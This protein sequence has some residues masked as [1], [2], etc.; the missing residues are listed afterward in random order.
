MSET[1]GSY[2]LSF[3]LECLTKE[4]RLSENVRRIFGY[5]FVVSVFYLDASSER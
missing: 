5:A 2:D 4:T 3:H 1:K